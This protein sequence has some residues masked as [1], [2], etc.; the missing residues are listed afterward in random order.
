MTE[1]GGVIKKISLLSLE[2]RA[3]FLSGRHD[4]TVVKLLWRNILY[5]HNNIRP[6]VVIRGMHFLG[7]AFVQGKERFTFHGYCTSMTV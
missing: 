4:Y 3:A 6:H 7:G 5:L 1:C 2:C